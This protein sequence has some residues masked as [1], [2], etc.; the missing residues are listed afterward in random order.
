MRTITPEDAIKAASSVARDIAEGRLS[1]DDLE[2]RAVAELTALAGTVTGP[3]DPLWPVQVEIAR[4]VLAA[5][6][7]DAD[8]LREWAAVMGQRPTGD[9]RVS[10][11]EPGHA[12][13]SGELS[14]L[15]GADRGPNG[16]SESDATP[17]QES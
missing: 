6:G 3:G 7:I 13:T 11:A 1:P 5:G 10:D 2:H 4:G 15:S 9:F 16:P 12:D 17:A 14:S 8:E